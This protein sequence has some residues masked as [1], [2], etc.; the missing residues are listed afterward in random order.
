MRCRSLL[1][2]ACA[3]LSNTAPPA[4]GAEPITG[5]NWQRHSAIAEIRAI[6]REVVKAESTGAL[7]RERRAFMFCLSY[8]DDERT[9]HRDAG[10]AVRKYS[11]SRG[12]EDSAAQ[13]TYYYDHQG[14]LRF[15]FAAAGAANGTRCEYRIY[16]DRSGKRL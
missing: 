13:A 9:L 5:A 10:G 4:A 16:L 12:S 15:V 11:L 2:S 7:R 1:L 3:I 14:A 8:E 6:Y